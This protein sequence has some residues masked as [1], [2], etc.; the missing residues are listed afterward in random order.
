MTLQSPSRPLRVTAP[1]PANDDI[2]D[3]ELPDHAR[4]PREPHPTLARR[5]PAA[6]RRTPTYRGADRPA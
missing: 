5:V 6:T 1:R 2:V 4:E 3:I